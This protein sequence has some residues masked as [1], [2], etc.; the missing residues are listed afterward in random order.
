[1]QMSGG[2]FGRLPQTLRE[3][4]TSAPAQSFLMATGAEEAATPRLCMACEERPLEVVFTACGHCLMCYACTTT[5]LQPGGKACPTCRTPVLLVGGTRLVAPP[6]GAG[7]EGVPFV[8]LDSFQPNEVQDAV[9]QR[10]R[11]VA[12]EEE[13]DDDEEE[14]MEEAEPWHLSETGIETLRQLTENDPD[15]TELCLSGTGIDDTGAAALAEALKVNNTL[16]KLEVGGNSIGADGAAALAEALKVNKTDEAGCRGQQHRR[17]WSQCPCGGAQGE[18]NA[19][20]AEYPWQQHLRCWHQ[21]HCGGAQG[22]QDADG[23][24]CWSQRHR[25]FWRKRPCKGAGGE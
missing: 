22:E 4:K 21:C 11:A 14:D 18:Q 24:V 9:R 20:K 15:R 12:E 16:T 8:R 23:A 5:F 19:D 17:C 1:M 7:A 2:V 6:A 10:A 13:E 25:R 3:H